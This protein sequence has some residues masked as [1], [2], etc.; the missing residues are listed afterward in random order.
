MHSKKEKNKKQSQAVIG[1]GV[2]IVE[3]SRVRVMAE[4]SPGFLERFF[5]EGELAYSMKSKNKYERLAA[6][7]AV[8]EAVIKALDDKRLALKGIEVENTASG[9]PQ[10]TVKGRPGA[11]LLVSISHTSKYAVASV[12][13]FG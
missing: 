5:T 9:R 6:R 13:A 1:L 4:R 8:K 7:F 10:V 12:V 2:D 3:V 11:R